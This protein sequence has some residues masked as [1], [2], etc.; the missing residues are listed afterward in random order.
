MSISDLSGV[1][2]ASQFGSGTVTGDGTHALTLTGSESG[3][4]NDTWWWSP[5]LV[6]PLKYSEAYNAKRSGAN[7]SNNVTASVVALP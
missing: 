5:A 7:Y 1:L 6:I 4:R 3:T 2:Q